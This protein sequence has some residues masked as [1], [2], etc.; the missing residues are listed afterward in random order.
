[1]TNAF[2]N[3]LRLKKPCADCPFRIEG[4]IDLA[5]GRL[6]GIIE[7]LVENDQSSF[8]C[9]KTVHCDKGGRW[10]E[11][12]YQPSGH[13]GMCA[14]AAAYLMKLGQPT[15]TMRVGFALG[16]AKPS[17]WDAAKS[18]VISPPQ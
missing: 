6:E 10:L 13:E 8:Q 2:E 15:V 1:M 5:P 12:G 16:V 4:A 18:L 11:D 9:H 17:D 3:H 7:S 14:G